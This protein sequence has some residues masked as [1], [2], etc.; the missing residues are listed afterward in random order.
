MFC[1]VQLIFTYILRFCLVHGCGSNG[2]E[3]V[4]CISRTPV[5][6]RISILRDYIY[7]GETGVGTNIGV[8]FVG[9]ENSRDVHLACLCTINSLLFFY[10]KEKKNP[11]YLSIVVNLVTS[12]WY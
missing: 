9:R 2:M 5:I 1:W 3:Q 11:F 10:P 7:L 12:H 6:W 8:N 4:L